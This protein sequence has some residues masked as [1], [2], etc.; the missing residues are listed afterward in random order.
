MTPEELK[1]ILGLHKKWLDNEEGG[2][3]ANLSH[4]NLRCANLSHADLRSANL[5]SADL[6]CANLR[7]ANLS[8]ADLRSANLRSADLRSANLRS[9]DLRSANL[10]SANLRSADLRSANLRSANLD[11]AAWPLWCGSL[12][13]TVDDRLLAQLIYHS[14]AV[15]APATKTLRAVPELRELANSFHRVVSGECSAIK[16]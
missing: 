4:A 9:A 15:N 7:C 8:H 11:F 6:R 13:V 3:C 5:R 14:L 12:N 10:R 1:R 2:E 16:G